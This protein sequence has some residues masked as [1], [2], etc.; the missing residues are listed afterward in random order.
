ML[1]ASLTI[2][3][4]T[5][6]LIIIAEVAPGRPVAV[7]LVAGPLAAGGALV[8]TQPKYN[9]TIVLEWGTCEIIALSS[10]LRVKSGI[11]NES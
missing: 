5:N 3:Q 1:L 9:A 2:K 4:I 8:E 7:A 10:P 6:P 11:T